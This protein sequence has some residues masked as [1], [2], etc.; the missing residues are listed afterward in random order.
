MFKELFSAG[1]LMVYPLVALAI[2][3]TVF[4][5]RVVA[6][7]R[8]SKEDVASLA[9]LPLACDMPQGGHRER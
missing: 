2:F 9:R 1:P 7:M 8:Q 6:M 3:V 4:V 5:T